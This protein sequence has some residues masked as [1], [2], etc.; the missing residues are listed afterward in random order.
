MT[1]NT[2]TTETARRLAEAEH[3]L[4]TAAQILE[5]LQNDTET[6]PDSLAVELSTSRET[7]AI[8]ERRAQAART[9]H[10]AVLVQAAEEAAQAIEQKAA[11]LDTEADRITTEARAWLLERFTPGAVE[12]LLLR[13]APA[14]A[15]EARRIAANLRGRAEAGRNQAKSSPAQAI[16]ELNNV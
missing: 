15:I 6:D 14:A 7:L 13:E 5:R 2:T 4:A 9:A 11:A 16:K 12:A 8:C 10:H 1:T 3:N